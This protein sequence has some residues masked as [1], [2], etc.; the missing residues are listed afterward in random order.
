MTNTTHCEESE[1]SDT[2]VHSSPLPAKLS[3]KNAWHGFLIFLGF[4]LSPLSPW[5]DLFTNVPIAYATGLGLSFISDALFLPGVVFGYWLSN[6]V[7]F[8]LMHYGYV[9]IT[10]QAFSFKKHW[11]GYALSASLYT[12]VVVLLIQFNVLPSA[13]EVVFQLEHHL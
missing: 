11:K 4:W 2:A 12:V 9:G 8:V 10:A 3:F 6:V 7:G 1:P 13:E 5:N